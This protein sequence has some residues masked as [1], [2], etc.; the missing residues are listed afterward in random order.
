M[1]VAPPEQSAR[2]YDLGFARWVRDNVN[3]GKKMSM[4]MQ[5]G[6][7]SG[8]CPIGTEMDQGPRKLFMMI[9]AGMKDEVFNSSTIW[10]CTSCYNCVVRCP[11]GV[12]VTYIIQDLAA[13]AVELGYVKDV[14]NARFAKAFW[15]SASKY[16]RTDERLVTTKYYFSFGL[17]DFF[18]K[19]LGNL[20][21]AMGMVKTKRM[22]VGMPYKVKD[23]KGLQAILAKAAE[24]DARESKGGA[25]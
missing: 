16:G 13:K 21:I 17:A 8:S 14:E 12:P 23:T 22:H 5:C 18:K 20:K 9:R 25:Q 24:I 4:C 7:C 15:W 10:N 11:R 1:T 3:G 2:K 19:G 6:M